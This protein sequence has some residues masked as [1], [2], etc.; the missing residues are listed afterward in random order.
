MYPAYGG[1][2]I[3]FRF[4]GVK[5]GTLWIMKNLGIPEDYKYKDLDRIN[6][7]GHYE[8]GNIRWL[9]RR[10]NLVNRSGEQATAKMHWFR[11]RHPD[12]RYGDHQIRKLITM[13]LSPEQIVAR[14]NASITDKKK[15][16][17]G[18]YS[19]PDPAIASLVTGF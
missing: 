6:P 14:W 4:P 1:R 8:P 19:M 9:E 17:Y 2:G 18:T 12:V 15:Q 13:G 16:K 10:L 3:K 11:L 5:A 7:D